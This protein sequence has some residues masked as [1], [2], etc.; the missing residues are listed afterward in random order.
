MIPM[1]NVNK[2]IIRVHSIFLCFN[3]E[4]KKEEN[5]SRAKTLGLRWK[6][7]VFALEMLIFSVIGAS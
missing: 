3:V 6:M 5:Q 7:M 2:V 4:M 1:R